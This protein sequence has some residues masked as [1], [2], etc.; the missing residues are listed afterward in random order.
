MNE[1]LSAKELLPLS[2]EELKIMTAFLVAVRHG[3]GDEGPWK[4]EG[5]G[6]ICLKCGETLWMHNHE[7]YL[8]IPWTRPKGYSDACPVPPQILD[9]PEVV[10]ERLIKAVQVKHPR[11]P[12]VWWEAMG[13]I[14]DKII[15]TREDGFWWYIY[16][17]TP[18]Q[19]VLICLL[20]LGLIGE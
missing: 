18:V 12:C 11:R 15:E 9:P 8:K 4:H 6:A 20:A 1:K 19:R 16:D 10:V 17:S 14:A 7:G 5:E 3:L 2:W 13:A